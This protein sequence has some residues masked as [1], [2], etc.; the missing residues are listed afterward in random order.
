[1]MSNNNNKVKNEGIV[2]SEEAFEQG[3]VFLSD[4]KYKEAIKAFTRS[5]TFNKFNF[6][7][8]FYRGVANLDSNS[9]QKS[10]EDLTE[11]L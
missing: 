6:D 10:I 7:S 8:L 5:L 1:M 3:K 9:P 11:L 4:K 2:E